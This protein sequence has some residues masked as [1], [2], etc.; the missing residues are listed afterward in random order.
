M[1]PTILHSLTKAFPE[2]TAYENILCERHCLKA[3]RF[4]QLMSCHNMVQMRPGC[5]DV[6]THKSA[7]PD[8]LEK[9]IIA[10]FQSG[11]YW[12]GWKDR[13][14]Q[15][16]AHAQEI[17]QQAHLNGCIIK[18][19]GVVTRVGDCPRYDCCRDQRHITLSVFCLQEDKIDSTKILAIDTLIYLMTRTLPTSNM[20]P[21]IFRYS[22]RN[23]LDEENKW[24]LMYNSYII[25]LKVCA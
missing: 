21:R 22:T 16:R 12:M 14:V 3:S 19:T 23:F 20:E 5:M 9:H 24:H 13:A 2:S 11:L 7:N 25:F 17:L 6:V 4:E 10:S 8:K 1:Q 18:I 15:R